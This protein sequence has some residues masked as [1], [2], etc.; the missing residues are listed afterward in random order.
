MENVRKSVPDEN[1]QKIDIYTYGKVFWRKKLYLIVPVALALILSVMGVRFITPLY[2]SSSLVSVEEQ[3]ILAGTMRRYITEVGERN[4]QTRNQQFRTMIE[5]RV[6]SR[7]FL[8]MIIRDLGLHRAYEMHSTIGDAEHGG[9][10]LSE[11][12]LVIRRL[13]ELL[14]DKIAVQMT[15]PGVFAISVLDSDPRTAYVLAAKISDKFIEVTQLAK[16]QGLRQAGAFS[17]EQLAIYKEKLEE[18]ERELERIRRDLAVTDVERNPVTSANVHVAETRADALDAFVGGIELDLRRVRERLSTELD[19]IIPSTE[20]IPGDETI[21]NIE[22]RLAAASEER[23]LVELSGDSRAGTDEGAWE[24]RRQAMW[25]EIRARIGEIIAEE[26]DE[27]SEYVRPLI[28]E[29]FYQ[30]HQAQ[31]Y[32]SLERKLSG[33]IEQ[34]RTNL[35]RRPMLLREENRLEHEVETNRTTYEALFE[36]KT[37]AQITE[38]MQSTE[39]GV[40]ISIIEQAEQPIFPVKPDKL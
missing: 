6:M 39:L 37:S 23:I 40:Q 33:Y 36:S 7:T 18:S 24:T 22:R 21:G 9:S 13:V 4:V 31:F 5:T 27:L 28:T 20:R 3:N 19:G 34:Y 1:D 2:E 8:E 35:S 14:K 10:G 30:R 29:Y 25:E 15:V 26:Y 17:D 12:D 38:A 11:E 16:L 32:R